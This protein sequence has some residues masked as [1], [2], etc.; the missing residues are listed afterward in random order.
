MDE[1]K[2]LYSLT[3]S[4]YIEINKKIF[5]EQISKIRELNYKPVAALNDIIYVDQVIELT[6]LKKS[7]IYSKVCRFQ[8]PVLSRLR[9]LT[10]SRKDIT[11]WINTGRPNIIEVEAE[12]YSSK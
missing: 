4:E 2:P 12:K 10:F 9:P 11:N 6:G 8:I 3:I 5:S 1:S 7:T